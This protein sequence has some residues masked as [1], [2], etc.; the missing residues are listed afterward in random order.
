VALC[1]LPQSL[2]SNAIQLSLLQI[3]AGLAMSGVLVAIAALLA[4]YSSEGQQGITF[5]VN[6]S[7]VGGA[8][9]LAPMLGASAAVWWGLRSIFLA[10]SGLF[11]AGGFLTLLLFAHPKPDELTEPIESER[12]EFAL[13]G[14]T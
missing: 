6:T 1:F 4:T 8:N 5:G 12:R 7:I 3:A 14:E 13:D 2:V 11:A 10:A 9:A